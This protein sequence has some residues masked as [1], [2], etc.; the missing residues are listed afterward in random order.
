MGI[1]LRAQRWHQYVS[2][3]GIVDAGLSAVRARHARGFDRRS[4]AC[5]AFSSFC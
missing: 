2:F 5:Y 1:I 3:A 4:K